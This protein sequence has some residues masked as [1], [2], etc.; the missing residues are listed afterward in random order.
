MPYNCERHPLHRGEY[1]AY[2]ATGYAFRCTR[3]KFGGW[4]WF[5]TPSHAGKDADS[6]TFYADRLR[7]IAARIGK[8][9]IS[10]QG[11]A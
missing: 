10:Q 9:E 8:S 7:D 11:V 3:S 1:I 6:R 4:A 2:D 5:A